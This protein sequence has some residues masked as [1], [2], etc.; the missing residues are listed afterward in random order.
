M[1]FASK[2]NFFFDQNLDF[3]LGSSG[4]G[5]A[6]VRFTSSNSSM[7]SNLEGRPVNEIVNEIG[8]GRY[9]WILNL[10]VGSCFFADGSEILV[11]TT[12]S[13]A[14][15]VQWHLNAFVGAAIVS[16]VFVGAMIGALVE[17]KFGEQN[18]RV[19]SEM[20]I[21]AKIGVAILDFVG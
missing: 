5:A 20:R 17:E 19:L 14:L 16:V 4:Y 8:W 11:I 6:A 12:V 7:F 13:Q 18:F 1:L 21:L 15:T 3:V 2:F 10:I 9:N